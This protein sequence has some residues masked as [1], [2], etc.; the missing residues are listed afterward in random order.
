MSERTRCECRRPGCEELLPVSSERRARLKSDARVRIVAPGHMLDSGTV[1]LIERPDYWV[2][3]TIA[4]AD[5]DDD[6]SALSFPTSDPPAGA[7]S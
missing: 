7:S 1:V 6:P 2:V 3:R 4:A 5:E